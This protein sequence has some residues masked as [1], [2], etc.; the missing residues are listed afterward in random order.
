MPVTGPYL[1]YPGRLF[2]TEQV[3]H[4][5]GD[6]SAR[7]AGPANMR[8]AGPAFV[9]RFD[10][11]AKCLSRVDAVEA[12]TRTEFFQFGLCRFGDSILGDRFVESVFR[13]SHAHSVA[14]GERL[15]QPATQTQR[16]AD[17]FPQFKTHS[18]G[19]IPITYRSFFP[20]PVRRSAD[21]SARSVFSGRF[22]F[23]K[24]R[25]GRP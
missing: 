11:T 8:I 21:R 25:A 7:R 2:R 22:F 13:Q 3:E 5:R 9:C 24:R 19:C 12:D 18:A 1:Q 23:R 4:Q 20:F 10:R 15:A 14:P 16:R 17:D 6:D